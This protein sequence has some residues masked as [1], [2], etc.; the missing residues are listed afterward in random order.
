[1]N[2]IKKAYKKWAHR[3]DEDAKVNPA[4]VMDKDV[5]PRLLDV[6]SKDIVLDLGCGTGRFTVPIAKKTKKVIAADFSDDMLGI[7]QYKARNLTN[8][9]FQKVDVTKKFPWKDNTF[10]KINSGLLVDHVKDLYRF[11]QEVYRVLKKGGVFVYDDFAPDIKLPVKTRYDDI[12]QN[13][14]EK[15]FDIFSWHPIQEHVFALHRAGFKIETVEFIVID[16]KLEKTFAKSAYHKYKGR[17]LGVAFK[18]NK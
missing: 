9:E 4:T 7:A 17:T 18:A 3:Y 12:L 1:M 2:D 14:S 6:S 16:K 13:M 11:I 8:V 10:H 5:L 15:G